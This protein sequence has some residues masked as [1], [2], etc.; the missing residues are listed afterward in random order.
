M[1]RVAQTVFLVLDTA[2]NQWVGF[3][4]GF[5]IPQDFPEGAYQTSAVGLKRIP[6]LDPTTWRD[7]ITLRGR[8]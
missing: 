6:R 3:I 7:R 1:C 8:L 2:I 5:D 4:D